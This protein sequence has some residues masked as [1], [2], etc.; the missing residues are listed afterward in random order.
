MFTKPPHT[1]HFTHSSSSF[2][3]VRASTV[4]GVPDAGAS[5]VLSA[6]VRNGVSTRTAL[7]A[8]S[9]VAASS[10]DAAAGLVVSAVSD[11]GASGDISRDCDCG[12]RDCGRFFFFP[13]A[14]A[15]RNFLLPPAIVARLKK[16]YPEWWTRCRFLVSF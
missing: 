16:L 15:L 6:S 12:G 9:A 7:L 14:W 10:N 5:S 4:N 11:A 8:P 3:E 2:T 13:N 1:L